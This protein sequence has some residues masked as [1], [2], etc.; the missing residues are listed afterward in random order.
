MLLAVVVVVLHEEVLISAVS[1]KGH[2][3]Y[4]QSRKGTLEAVPSRELSSV[5]PCLAAFVVSIDPSYRARSN[6]VGPLTLSPRGRISA[7]Q[8][9]LRTCER[10]NQ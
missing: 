2:S 6:S 9:K 3:R 8:Q 10:R 4:A 1:R 5:S 7:G